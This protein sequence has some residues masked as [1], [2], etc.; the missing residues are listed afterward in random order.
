MIYNILRTLDPAHLSKKMDRLA[1]K[2]L[3]HVQPVARSDLHWIL[4]CFMPI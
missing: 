4:I 2:G 1:H 3:N